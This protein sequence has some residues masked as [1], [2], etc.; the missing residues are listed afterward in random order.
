MYNSKHKS[1]TQTFSETAHYFTN[2]LLNQSLIVVSRVFSFPS[3]SVAKAATHIA[4]R[5]VERGMLSLPFYKSLT[6]HDSGTVVAAPPY[7]RIKQRKIH[8][9]ILPYRPARSVDIPKDQSPV[10][11]DKP[12]QACSNCSSPLLGLQEAT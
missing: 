8:G 4:S 7:E 10:A 11:P 5:F 2:N 1:S 9:G 6:I 3:I 12:R